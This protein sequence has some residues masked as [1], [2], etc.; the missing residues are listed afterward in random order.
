[1]YLLSKI[2]YRLPPDKIKQLKEDCQA[3]FEVSCHLVLTAVT[4]HLATM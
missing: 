2:V 1:M 3:I 4:I